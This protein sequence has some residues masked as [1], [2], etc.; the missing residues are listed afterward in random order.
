MLSEQYKW[1]QYINRKPFTLHIGLFSQ[2]T[3]VPKLLLTTLSILY[4]K[5]ESLTPFFFFS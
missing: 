3:L 2:E 1:K 5:S 4:M